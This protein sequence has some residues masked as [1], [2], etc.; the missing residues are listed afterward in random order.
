MHY[1]TKKEFKQ[2]LRPALVTSLLFACIIVPAGYGLLTEKYKVSEKNLVRLDSIRILG[3]AYQLSDENS[4]QASSVE[5]ED[6]HQKSFRIGA[7]ALAA[8]VH[9][10][11]LLDTLQY[12]ATVM[13]I[14]TDKE[15]AAIYHSA[16]DQST[17][18]VYG[19]EINH[20]PQI[21]T[22]KITGDQKG[23]LLFSLATYSILY[24]GALLLIFFRGN[25]ET[26]IE[27]SI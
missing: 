21:E 17:I 25:R 13:T 3:K 8:A 2:K 15:G 12:S 26:K 5:F 20:I 11:F 7:P 27:L 14:Y 10:Q 16:S 23:S 22:S 1:P 4:Y 6:L 9:R 24:V 18:N 19:L